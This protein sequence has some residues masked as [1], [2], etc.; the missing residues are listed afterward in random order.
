MPIINLTKNN[1]VIKNIIFA[2]SFY[3][4]MKGLL[5]RKSL[6]QDTGMLFTGAKQIHCFFMGFTIDVVFL[7]KRKKVIKIYH[8]LKPWR[9]TSY[10]LRA[11]YV[12]ELPEGTARNADLSEG[13]KMSW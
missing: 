12:F 2:D 3:K 1:I 5:G 7:D 9:V 4:K 11:K 10:I 8:N 13:D 6:P